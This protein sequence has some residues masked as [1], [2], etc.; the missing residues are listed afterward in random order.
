VL[1]LN[2]CPVVVGSGM[3]LFDGITDQIHLTLVHTATLSNGVVGL[4]YGP[5]DG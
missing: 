3:R 4:T 5:A 2:V 1:N